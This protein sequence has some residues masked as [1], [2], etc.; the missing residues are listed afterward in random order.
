MIN[1]TE[2]ERTGLPQTESEE[3]AASAGSGHT[4]L[5][6][7]EDYLTG[8]WDLRKNVLKSMFE[9]RPKGKGAWKEGDVDTISRWMDKES[10]CSLPITKLSSLLASDFV[11][12]FHAVRDYL[13]RLKPYDEAEGDTIAAY[14]DYVKAEDQPAFTH[15]FRK[16]VMRMVRSALNPKEFNKQCFVLVQSTHD[17]GKSTWCRNMCPPEL[18][19]FFKENF[20]ENEKDARICLAENWVVSLD[21]LA[22]MDKR[23]INTLKSWFST[24]AVKERRAFGKNNTRMERLA[25]FFGNTNNDNDFLRDPTGSVRWV[26]FIIESINFEYSKVDVGRCYA[27]AKWH[28]ER[29]D[30]NRGNL[31][32]QEIKENEIRNK[33]FQATSME[34]DLIDKH[35]QPV[36]KGHKGAW[37][38]NATDISS[39]VNRLED[40]AGTK[41]TINGIG[42]AL[43]ALN[44]KVAKKETRQYAVVYKDKSKAPTREMNFTAEEP[45]RESGKIAAIEES[46]MDDGDAVVY[47]RT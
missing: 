10:H 18:Q 20:P 1:L 30:H 8:R 21:E 36:D 24:D 43:H 9:Y 28:L 47:P 25:S 46:E 40:S 17:G 5:D 14:A 15:H 39:E 6:Q 4:K 34:Q 23:Q 35:F 29:G 38:Y 11:P 13:A 41:M 42:C 7:A 32:K 33:Q 19:D 3:Q 44:F 16:H 27:M 45:E 26:C 22:D 2:A 37:F 31:T 12:E